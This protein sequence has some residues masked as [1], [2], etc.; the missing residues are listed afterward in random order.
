MLRHRK[1]R[2]PA[3]ARRKTS[4]RRVAKMPVISGLAALSIA[5]AACPK[6]EEP[7]KKTAVAIP[8]KSAPPREAAPEV[9]PA[10]APDK[11]SDPS[12]IGAWAPEGAPSKVQVGA[13]TFDLVGSWL[14]ETSTD[15]DDQTVL[16]VVADIKEDTPENLKNLKTIVEFFKGEKAEAIVI[17]GDLG[18]TQSQIANVLEPL[19]ATGLP[20]FA[21]IGNRESKG[22]FNQAVKAASERHPGVFNLNFV[23]L[24]SLDDVALISMPGYYNKDY[25]HVENGCNYKPSDVEAMK[26]IIRAAGEKSIVL[27]SHGP[28]KQD[29]PEALDRTLEQANVGDPALAR[30]I[31]ETGIKFGI[32]ANIHEAGG[33]ATDLSGTTLIS[34]GRLSPELFLNPGPADAVRWSM[35]DRTESVGLAA[36]L[37]I[38]GRQASFKVHRI[39]L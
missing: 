38:R 8:E 21:V 14:R 6:T 26:P 12:C 9:A 2:N 33:R 27:V 37:T 22:D 19:A 31:Q 16:G 34:A 28:P 5:T 32:F 23:R 35:N 39:A 10:A 29:G 3:R 4:P 7:E 1:L 20:T 25:I 13:R 15:S 24:V 17:A 11:S 30:F 36:V 18:E